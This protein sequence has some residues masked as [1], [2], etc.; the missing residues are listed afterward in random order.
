MGTRSAGRVLGR[1]RLPRRRTASETSGEAADRP[2]ARGST[3]VRPRG[4][5]GPAGSGR[6]HPDWFA[7]PSD[8]GRRPSWNSSRRMAASVREYDSIPAMSESA[9]RVRVSAHDEHRPAGASTP[10]SQLQRARPSVA[11]GTSSRQIET[12]RAL[13]EPGESGVSPNEASGDRHVTHMLFSKRTS[14]EQWGQQRR[15]WP[16]SYRYGAVIG[17]WFSRLGRRPPRRPWSTCR[18]R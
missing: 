18:T 11:H 15:G 14:A 2:R 10:A 6:A 17:G 5:D 4:A 9:G 1:S 7:G 8:V 12:G 16:D 3:S 13:F